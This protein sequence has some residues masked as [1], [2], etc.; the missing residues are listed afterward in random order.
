LT[1]RKK[2]L[3][4]FFMEPKIFLCRRGPGPAAQEL[5]LDEEIPSPSGPRVQGLIPDQCC[6]IAEISVAELER[7][8]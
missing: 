7:E 1:Q 2:G 6:Q 3:D 8:G 5:A 4:I